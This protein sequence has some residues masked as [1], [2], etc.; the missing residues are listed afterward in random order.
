M[1]RLITKTAVVGSGYMG[2]GIAQVLALAGRD[3]MLADVSADVAV[4]NRERIVREAGEYAA[5]GIFPVDAQDRV[6]EHVTAA[7]SI[8]E[9]VSAADFIEEAVPEILAVK[10]ETLTASAATPHPP[11]SSEATR[12]RSR[13]ARSPKPSTAPRDSSGSI[14]AIPRPSSP[15]SRSSPM[16][17]RIPR[18]CRR[19]SNC[20]VNAA[21]SA[22][23]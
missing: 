7:A 12:R 2:G 16:W 8:E 4:T 11:P 20:S 9:A 18:S 15:A 21:R 6:A 3:V 17:P 19:S 13:S 22:F 5:R 14:S 10:Q 1:T 23:R